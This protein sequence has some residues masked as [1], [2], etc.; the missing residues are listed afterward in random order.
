MNDN[1]TF[2]IGII[3]FGPKGFYGF[4]RLVAYLNEAKISKTTEVHIFNNTAFLAS[5]DVY[6]TD[7]PDYLIMNYANRNINSWVLKEPFSM[8]SAT[9][10]FVTWLTAK[11]H[12]DAAQG[13]Y[14]P[15]AVVGSYLADCYQLVLEQLPTNIKVI[16]HIGKV[17]DMIKQNE[18]YQVFY[19]D[20]KSGEQDV[21]ACNNILFT[22]GHHSFKA[23]KPESV[24]SNHKID[25]IYPTDEK[26][27]PVTPQSLVAIK[28]FGL[29]AIDAIL[30]LTE[31]R[32]AIFKKNDKGVLRYISSEKEPYKIY[33]FSRT[34]LPMVPR[35]GS[36]TSETTLQ[37]FTKEVVQHLKANTP[38][39]F[40]STLLPLIK[41]EF[42]YAFY[43]VLFNNNGHQFYY[44]DD[45][46]VMQNQVQYF[47]ED[48]P[49]SPV[50]NWET[51]VN[52]FKDEHILSS[53]VLQ[54]YIGF[55]ID[56]AKLGEDKSPFMAAVA[57][58]RKISPIFNELYSFGGLDAESH[59]E[60]DTYYFGLFNRLSYGPPV[61]NMQKILALCKAGILDFSYAKSASITPN[62]ENNN[63]TIQ[64]E[65]G[66]ATEINYLIN[67]TIARA[68]ESG[69]G[70]ELYQNLSKN[71]LIREF[72]N[73]G[74]I[75]G[76]L[77]INDKGNPISK[78][79]IVN[80]DITFY[81][82]PTEG[83]TCDNDTLSRT[84]N[85]FATNWAKSTTE[86]IKEKDGR[87]EDYDR[88]ENV[89]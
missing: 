45:F 3:G 57:T 37:F 71:G 49:E 31:G 16:T 35:N 67:A 40:N 32:G 42:Y 76:C 12:T 52:P 43:S 66:Q 64:V 21:V 9:P 56:E 78:I 81:G 84:R 55:L 53:V 17:T 60:F 63:F 79:G 61:K 85:D 80:N 30:A 11:G 50:F 73:T 58:W 1:N 54:V 33:T 8:A 62:S 44:D 22:T 4:E 65:K 83:I 13:E 88:T 68:K 86:A 47:H 82:T 51:I 6:R 46:T 59:K 75:P 72:E 36:P 74:Y 18:N 5:G 26:L 20:R 39:N 7:Q 70:N 69:F 14:A 48:Y 77:E 15:R 25:F 28:G 89:L 29:T 2:K 87:T 27:S 24:I 10:D 34:G 19:T 23:Q 38:I 41:K